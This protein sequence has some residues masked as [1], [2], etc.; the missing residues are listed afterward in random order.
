MTHERRRPR[1][2]ASADQRPFII[3]V[4]VLQ[5]IAREPRPWLRLQRLCIERTELADRVG[6]LAYLVVLDGRENGRVEAVALAER[7]ALLERDGRRFWLFGTV[8]PNCGAGVA[9]V[10]ISRDFAGA[11]VRQTARLL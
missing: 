5:R 1:P 7:V 2:P 11:A 6:Q 8:S 10:R 4:N 9:Q 3:S